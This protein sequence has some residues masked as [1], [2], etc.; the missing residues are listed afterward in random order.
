MHRENGNICCD[1]WTK[2]LTAPTVDLKGLIKVVFL[3]DMDAQYAVQNTSFPRKIA[4]RLTFKNG[5]QLQGLSE[6]TDNIAVAIAL[7]KAVQTVID[8]ANTVAMTREPVI[9]LLNHRRFPTDFEAVS[10][11]SHCSKRRSP[12]SPSS[13]PLK[14]RILAPD[15]GLG[16][17][18]MQGLRCY[19]PRT[20]LH[21]RRQGRNQWRYR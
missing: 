17:C 13:C 11:F 1:R 20:S 8:K 21:P 6:D 10:T 2:S 3:T 12:Q 19:Q 14:G 5:W 7:L 9:L 16:R 15:Q 4:Y 18:P